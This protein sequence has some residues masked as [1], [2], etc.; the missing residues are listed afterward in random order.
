M[1]TK[2]Y[3]GSCVCKA[4]RFEVDLDL[5]KGTTKCNCTTCSKRRWWGVHSKPAEFRS[6]A[7]ADALLP[8]R[9]TKLP[10]GFC[11]HCGVTCYQ[12]GEGAEW[13][14]G[15]YVSVNVATLDGVD[16]ATWSALPVTYLDG[17]HDTW[18]PITEHTSHL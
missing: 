11:K 2:T 7:G 10:G 1:S 3:Q 14:D 12:Y 9:P 17:L 13:N 8:M 16:H 5:T 18:D 15:D 4:V 6:L